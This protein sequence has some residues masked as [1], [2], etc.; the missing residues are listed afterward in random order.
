M[1][2]V[3]L[4]SQEKALKEGQTISAID[5]MT[6]SKVNLIMKEGVVC[7]FEKTNKAP[8]TKVQEFEG[9]AQGVLRLGEQEQKLLN[10]NGHVKCYRSSSPK[11]KM[12]LENQITLGIARTI[13]VWKDKN[14]NISWQDNLSGNTTELKPDE[15]KII[16]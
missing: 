14:G 5:L 16:Q 13:D 10:E 7:T 2:I 12:S 9:I 11:E 15:V 8:I 4:A 6:Q 3:L 1:L